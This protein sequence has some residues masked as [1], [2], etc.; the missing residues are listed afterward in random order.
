MPSLGW[1]CERDLGRMPVPE[2]N[3]PADWRG[4]PKEGRLIDPGLG[5]AREIE[6]KKK[7][8]KK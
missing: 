1:N 7:D 8:L 4:G 5:V 3:E 6:K 2:H